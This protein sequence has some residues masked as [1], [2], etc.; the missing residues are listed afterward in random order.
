MRLRL[1]AT[2]RPAPSTSCALDQPA[3]LPARRRRD[4]RAGCYELAARRTASACW[5]G[6]RERP[7]PWHEIMPRTHVRPVGLRATSEALLP[8]TLRRLSRATACCSEYFA[9]PQRYLF[10]D[11]GRPGHGG[12]AARRQRAGDR[13]AVRRAAT[14]ALESAVDAGELRRCS[15]RRRSTCFP[16]A[17]TASTSPR[18]A[19]S[20]TSWPTAPGRWTSRSSKSSSVT[21]YG[22]GADGEQELPAVLRRAS[23]ASADASIGRTTP[24]QREPR[25]LS[26]A[27]QRTGPR[28][29]YVGSEVVPRRW[30]T[31]REAPFSD[32]PAPAGGDR[33]VHQPRPAA[34]PCRS[35]AAKHATSPWSRRRAGDRNPLPGGPIAARSVAAPTATPAWQLDQPSVAELPV[36]RRTATSARARRRCANCSSLYGDAGGRRHAQADRGRASGRGRAGHAP[37]CRSRGR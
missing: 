24:S 34:A 20:T 2:R 10:V 30:W 18:A 12:A 15:A 8:V 21:G 31:P 36:A 7:A 26:A 27:Q 17:A 28:S 9:F 4:R 25:L 19:S 14:R 13:A 6:R 35:G 33:P 5:C 3:P 29:S 1:R 32:R 22:V 11:L 16:S 37:R 23:H